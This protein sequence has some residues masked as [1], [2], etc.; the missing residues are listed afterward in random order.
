MLIFKCLSFFVIVW[1]RCTT[2]IHEIG[3][4]DRKNSAKCSRRN[5][6]NRE[7]LHYTISFREEIPH[8]AALRSESHQKT[9]DF[10]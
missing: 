4:Q 5:Y 9:V 10:Y 1:T 8:Y 7:V 6:K 3:V 2:S